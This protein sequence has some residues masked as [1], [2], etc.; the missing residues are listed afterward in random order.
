MLKREI[1]IA[2]QAMFVACYNRR[3]ESRQALALETPI[4]RELEGQ[5]TVGGEIVH[6]VGHVLL[7]EMFTPLQRNM[8]ALASHS[9]RAR[10]YP[11]LLFHGTRSLGP[12]AADGLVVEF[13][14]EFSVWGNHFACT[15]RIF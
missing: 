8:T 6:P 5:P 1:V 7:E 10:H 9:P 3:Q 11:P 4:E 13:L 2:L 14:V 15:S 12:S